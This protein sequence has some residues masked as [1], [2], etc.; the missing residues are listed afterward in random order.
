MRVSKSFS[1]TDSSLDGYIIY[2]WGTT[3]GQ[4]WFGI[5]LLMGA[6]LFIGIPLWGPPLNPPR[7]WNPWIWG[8][9][10]QENIVFLR[11]YFV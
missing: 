9:A 8:P 2:A 5:P 1:Y 11:A 7:P 3:G 4:T 10:Y 6:P